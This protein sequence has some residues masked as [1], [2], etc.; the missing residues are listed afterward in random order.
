[1]PFAALIAAGIVARRDSES[2]ARKLL[3]AA[4]NA[5]WPAWLRSTSVR[6]LPIPDFWLGVA[7]ASIWSAA[8]MLG[9]EMARGT[10]PPALLFGG[11]TVVVEQALH[12]LVR[13]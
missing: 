10:V 7:P 5:V 12:V 8:T 11:V 3:F 4:L 9:A 6:Q 1:M 13:K 2:R